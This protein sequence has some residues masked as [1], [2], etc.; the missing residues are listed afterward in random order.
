MR[1]VKSA[2]LML[3]AGAALALAGCDGD[4][5]DDFAQ[6][7]RMGIPAVNTAVIPSGSKDAFNAGDPA[8]DA[9]FVALAEG[10]IT[11]LRNAVAAVPGFPPEDSAGPSA[12]TIA[13]VL[14]PDAIT[15]DLSQPVGFPNGRALPDD[16]VDVALG[17]VLNRGNVLGGGPGVADDIGNDSAFLGTF[18]Y[19]AEPQ[20]P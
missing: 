6:F 5:G 17:L 13:G 1:R 11:T 9:P 20:G 2:H 3:A 15:L 14:I 10:R 12:A 16:V 7:D 8:T 18:P 19:L 4:G